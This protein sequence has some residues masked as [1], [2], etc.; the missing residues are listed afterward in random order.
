MSYKL[1]QF[2]GI[3]RLSDG[4]TLPARFENGKLV[5]LDPHSPFVK[6]LRE[7]IAA[8][9]TPLPA[10]PTPAPIPPKDIVDQIIE[11]SPTRRALLKVELAKP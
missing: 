8:G 9:N 3:Q 2:N 4:A 10:D 11:L 7:W 6:E 1:T 5:E